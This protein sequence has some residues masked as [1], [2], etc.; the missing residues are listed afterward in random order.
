MVAHI[1]AYHQYILN[2]KN[3]KVVIMKCI[4]CGS[5]NTNKIDVIKKDDLISLYKKAFDINVENIIK[6]DLFYHHCCDCD[7]RFFTLEN[8]EIPSGDDGFYNHLN[9]LPW[10]Y[11]QEKNEYHFAKQFIKKDSRVLEVGCGKAAFASFL[12]NKQNY[13]GLEFS[14]D[15][16]KLA[17]QNG[18]NIE[19]ISI[20]EYSKSNKTKFNIAC[21]FQVLEHVTNPYSFIHSQIKCLNWGGAAR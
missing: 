20:E 17:K 6:Q 14:S 8:G 1:K 12:P 19:N 7:L 9:K 16:K 15:A 21:S 5:D 11:M 18:I 13:I 3:K 4:L 2:A 10:Y